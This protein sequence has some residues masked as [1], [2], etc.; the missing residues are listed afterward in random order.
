MFSDLLS[1]IALPPLHLVRHMPP[2]QRSVDAVLAL[3]QSLQQAHVLTETFSGKTVALTCGSRD[4]RDIV[5]ILKDLGYRFRKLGAKPFVVPA[6]G[7]HGG[8]TADGQRAIL[9]GLG[10]TEASIEMPIRSSMQTDLIAYTPDGIPVYMDRLAHR[11][12][13]VIPIGRVKPHTEFHGAIESGVHKMIAVGLG[14]QQGASACHGI[15][16]EHLSDTITSVAQTALYTASIPFG[17][18]ILETAQHATHSVTV[19]PAKDLLAKEKEL[20]IE[21][22]ALIPQLPCSNLDVLAVYE[23]GKDICGTGMDSN[24]TGRSIYLPPAYPYAKILTVLRLTNKSHHNAN[25]I[26]CADVTTKRLVDEIDPRETF[27]NAISSFDTLACRTPVYMPND[28]QALQAS[29]L[30]SKAK[31]RQARIALIRNTLDLDIMYLS[32]AVLHDGICPTCIHLI[33]ENVA[34]FSANGDL[35]PSIWSV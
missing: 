14:K 29:L 6:M 12:D 24:V 7:S 34:L 21:A 32:D 26:G 11:A 2:V 20:L 27:P 9:T 19:I 15:G 13:F 17:I 33:Q 25:G 30:F 16:R 3:E 31:P 28:M 4:I 10:V 23:M 5:P 1:D 35:I 18:A 22:K 8:A